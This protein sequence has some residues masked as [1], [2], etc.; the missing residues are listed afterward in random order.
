MCLRSALCL[1]SVCLHV[2]MFVLL[3]FLCF[4]L[5]FF[6]FPFFGAGWRCCDVAAGVYSHINA[7]VSFS[8]GAEEGRI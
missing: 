7:R 4:L 8:S 6:L 1:V 3:P 5:A 2:G